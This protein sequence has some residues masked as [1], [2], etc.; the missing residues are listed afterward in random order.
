MSEFC[1]GLGEAVTMAT[2][3]PPPLPPPRGVSR[4]V[5][6]EGQGREAVEEMRGCKMK[7]RKEGILAET[8]SVA[9]H[10]GLKKNH[11]PLT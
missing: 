4:S 9:F 1:D 7:R 11:V 6:V 8:V 3:P 10:D 2:A 5:S